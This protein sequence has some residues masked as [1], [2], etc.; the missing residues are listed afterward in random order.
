[1]RFLAHERR[2]AEALQ[3]AE[4]LQRRFEYAM[5]SPKLEKDEDLREFVQSPLFRDWIKKQQQSRSG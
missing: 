4:I 1:M 2:Y 5:D 3:L